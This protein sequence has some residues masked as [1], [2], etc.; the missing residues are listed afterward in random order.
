MKNFDWEEFKGKGVA[1]CVSSTEQF[2]DFKSKC[3]EN[4]IRFDISRDLTSGNSLWFDCLVKHGCHYIDE[5][6]R[7]WYR[8]KNYQLI[9]WT[10][11]DNDIKI[12]VAESIQEQTEFT[13]QEVIARIKDGEYYRCTR[14]DMYKVKNIKMREGNIILLGNFRDGVGI[15]IKQLFVQEEYKQEYEIYYI[16]F[17]DSKEQFQFRYSKDNED[18]EYISKDD[19]V[20]C[21]LDNDKKAY[22]KVS[23]LKEVSMTEKEYLELNLIK[24]ID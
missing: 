4:N 19:I 16:T 12:E 1:V 20:I 22:G 21:N 18:D 15:N 10:L 11:E 2:N 23:D 6:A 24:S 17:P 9:E 3:K 13:Y 7:D 5:G 14:D 8:N